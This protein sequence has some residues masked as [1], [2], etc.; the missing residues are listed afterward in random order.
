MLDHV[1]TVSDSIQIACGVLSTLTINP[2]KMKASLDPFMLVSIVPTLLITILTAIKA[3]DLADFLVKRG[4]PFRETHHISGQC[5]AHSEKTGIPMNQMT[6]EDFQR[7]DSRFTEE[8]LECFDYDH[9]VEMHSAIGGTARKSVMG[10]IEI[11]KN[12][13]Q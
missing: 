13:L 8:V 11:L 3:T 6:F 4:V 2:E 7:I 1:K 5:V 12:M 10:Q 9:S